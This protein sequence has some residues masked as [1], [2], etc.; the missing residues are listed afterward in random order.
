MAP[1]LLLAFVLSAQDKPPEKCSLS[2]TVVNSVTGEPLNKVDLVLVPTERSNRIAAVT[3]SDSEGRFTMVDLDPGSYHL[4]GKRNGY[5]DTAYGARRPEG[6]GTVLRLEAGQGLPELKLKLM[7]FGVIAGVVR[8]SDGEPLNGAHVTV[9]RLTYE[10]GKP[11]VEGYGDT[12]TDD[13]GQYRL[14]GLPPGKYYVGVKPNGDREATRVDHSS[15]KAAAEGPVPTVY[16]G[17]AD[18]SLAAPIEVATGARVGGIDI[19]MAR[20]RCYTVSGRVAT[21]AGAGAPAAYIT[22]RGQERGM[23]LDVPLSTTTRNAN[24]DFEL[25][26]VPPGRYQLAATRGGSEVAVVPLEVAGNLEGVRAVL[27]KGA[28][29]KAGMV[30]EGGGRVKPERFQVFLTVNGQSGYF[31]EAEGDQ[32]ATQNNVAPD[33]YEVQV[34]RLAAGTYVKSI[35]SGDTDV[36]NDGLTIAPGGTVQFEITLASDAAKVEGTVTNQSDQPGPGATVV[37]VPE[38]KFRARGDLFKTATTDQYGH[39]EFATVAPGEYKVFAWDDV[40]PGIWNDPEFLKEHEKKGA[41][42]TAGAKGHATVQVK[43]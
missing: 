39:F 2:G 24:G 3:T 36:L 20:V 40:E 28:Q 1:L 6:D 11:R 8:D 29:V 13:L 14:R 42:V 19:K 21:G 34:E 26:G 33:R 5:L 32:F 37:L 38:P 4:T 35:R 7:P 12:E 23:E 17:S 9:A 27:G 43:L 25:R 18:A 31:L 15:G 30:M 10:Y 41:A 22:L 16:P